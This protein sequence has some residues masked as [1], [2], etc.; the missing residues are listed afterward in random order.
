MKRKLRVQIDWSGDCFCVVSPDIDGC[1]AIS[2]TLAQAKEDYKTSLEMHSEFA[3]ENNLPAWVANGAFE[4]DWEL[5]ASAL[6]KHYSA[7]VSLSAISRATGI[8]QRQLSHYLNGHRTPRAD[9]RS[10]IVK[11]LHDIGS[12]LLLAQ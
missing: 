8:N 1:V 10:S 4:F 12:E 6:L 5:T 3:E 2:S 7:M 9:K 11:G